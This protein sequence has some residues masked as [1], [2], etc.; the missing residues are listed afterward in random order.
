MIELKNVSFNYPGAGTG[1]RDVS[2]SLE[3]GETVALIGSNGAG[4]STLSRLIRGLLRPASGQILLDG[5]DI[6]DLKVSSLAGRIGFLFQNPDRQ[7]CRSTVREELSYSLVC[8]GIKKDQ[9]AARI[10]GILREFAFPPD[11]EPF[12]LSRGERQ[13][14]ALASVLVCEPEIL[15]LDEPT[16]GLDR[17][18]CEHI[19]ELVRER[20][21]RGGT[22]LMVC[23]DMELVLE[24]SDRVIVMH[25]GELLAQGAPREIFY[26]SEL[27]SQAGL[28]PPQIIGLSQALGE[29]FGRVC[30]PSELADAVINARS[31]IL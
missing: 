2:F 18:E 20:S 10:D 6:A 8:A 14:L 30:I 19:M 4:K 13:L 23:H 24:H 27:L 31:V 5:E 16:T 22:A 12:R 29:R 7:L 9:H 26:R 25:D 21:R 15:I 11:A 3:R 1:V 28:L 17:D